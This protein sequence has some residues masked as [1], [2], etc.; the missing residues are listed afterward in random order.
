[1]IVA[2]SVS[3]PDSDAVLDRRFGRAPAFVLVDTE[4]GTRTV[5]ANPAASRADEA[6][7]QAA[8]FLVQQGA[9]VV[10]SA[11]FGPYAFDVLESA[12]V[13]MYSA[14]SGTVAEILEQFNNGGLERIRRA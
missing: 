5:H 13:R 12:R 7:L 14:A 6:G 2:I 10:I 1:M 9:Q 11:V 3:E 4:T 8:E